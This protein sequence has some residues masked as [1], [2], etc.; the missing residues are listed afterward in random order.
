MGLDKNILQRSYTRVKEGMENLSRQKKSSNPAP[1]AAPA[2]AAVAPSALVPVPE[3]SGIIG[4]PV[5][6]QSDSVKE[7][8]LYSPHKQKANSNPPPELRR[9]MSAT[10]SSRLRIS[11]KTAASVFSENAAPAPAPSKIRPRHSI[12]EEEEPEPME[13]ST[14]QTVS[15]LKK[16][17]RDSIGELP[18][19]TPPLRRK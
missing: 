19:Y 15:P 17:K 12:E 4:N 3:N 7:V 1:T 6:L 16:H 2:P 13:L 11:K 5:L 8:Q 18:V 14:P 10:I 9:G